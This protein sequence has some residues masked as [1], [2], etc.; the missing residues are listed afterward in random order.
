MIAILSVTGAALLILAVAGPAVSA[1]MSAAALTVYAVHAAAGICIRYP[2]FTR[3]LYG[4]LA[5]EAAVL[6][7][8]ACVR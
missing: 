6:V 3:V 1:V 7:V 4:V 5:M 8:I 2:I